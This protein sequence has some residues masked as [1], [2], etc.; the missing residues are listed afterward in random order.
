[1]SD[2]VNDYITQLE[3]QLRLRG[4]INPR[5]LA[6][7]REH[8]L[9]AVED[10]RRRGLSI[11]DAE[12][13]ACERFG[14]P[15]VVAA[16]IRRE[17]RERMKSAFKDALAVVSQR[18]WLIV[19]PTLFAAVVSGFAANFFLPDRYRSEVRLLVVPPQVRDGVTVRTSPDARSAELRQVTE[20]LKS[21]TRL[22]SV[23]ENLNLFPEER[24]HVSLDHL[25]EQ[26][27]GDIHLDMI[28]SDVFSLS[29]VS[30]DPETARDVAQHLAAVAIDWNMSERTAAVESTNDFIAM[31][32]SEVR[33]QILAQERMLET[34]RTES[35]GRPLSQAY[36]IPYETLKETYRALLV[37]QRDAALAMNVERR[38]MGEQFRILDAARLPEQS[39]FQGRV[40]ITLLGT[41]IGLMLGLALVVLRSSSNTRPP[42][43]AE[44]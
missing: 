15:D 16:H 29:F 11:A 40:G 5:I 34:L 24:K 31:Q 41:L 9:D 23:I 27:R 32:I 7:A 28:S 2:S 3:G 19:V 14:A 4:I 6:E 33:E 38:Q 39:E 26:M 43:L 1:M 10:G 42:A 44:A 35:D 12:H 25:I 20:M 17:E 30:A 18:K 37:K 8:L 13:E 21:R 22:E 36:L